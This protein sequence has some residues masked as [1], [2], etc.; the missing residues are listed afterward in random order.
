[1]LE[2]AVVPFTRWS[3]LPGPASKRLSKYLGPLSDRGSRRASILGPR[4]LL[5]YLSAGVN[6]AKGS[7]TQLHSP[8]LLAKA[9]VLERALLVLPGP[10]QQLTPPF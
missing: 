5:R 6:P 4:Y 10:F 9:R 1:M 7:C 2:L 8:R 3:L